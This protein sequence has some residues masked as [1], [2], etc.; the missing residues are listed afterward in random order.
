MGEESPRVGSLDEISHQQAGNREKYRDA[1]E[2]E[3]TI[4]SGCPAGIAEMSA[5]KD[6]RVKK[7]DE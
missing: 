3:T 1:D 4:E 2:T 6:R 7:C 5:G